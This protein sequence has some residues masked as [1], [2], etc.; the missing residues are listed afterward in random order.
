VEDRLAVLA[1]IRPWAMS[2]ADL[3]AAVDR[4]RALVVEADA[5][6]LRLVREVDARGIAKGEGSSSTAVWDARP[7][8]GGGPVGAPAGEDGR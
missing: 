4:A 1:R 5:V 8:P 7:V 6:L 2:S 3:V